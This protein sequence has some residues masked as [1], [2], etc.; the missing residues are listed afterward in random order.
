MSPSSGA[1]EYYLL[2]PKE[3]MTRILQA[4]ARLGEKVLVLGHHY[5]RDDVMR[6]ADVQGDTLSLCLEGRQRPQAE[7]LVL[8]GVRFMAEAADL[9]SGEHQK[10]ILPEPTAGCPLAEMADLKQLEACWEELTELLGEGEVLPLAA[11]PSSAEAK[12]L[13]GR[14]GGAVCAPSNA[15]QVLAWALEQASRVLFFPDQHL[16]RNAGA[17]VGLEEEEMVVWD[18]FRPQGGLSPKT[19]RRARLIL[20]KGHCPV[21][22]RFTLQQVRQMKALNPGLRVIVHGGCRLEVAQAADEW[23]S[24]EDIRRRIASSPPGSQWAVGAELHLV[25]RL[26]KENPDKSILHLDS[27][28]CVCPPMFRIG[29]HSLGWVLE[30]LVQGRIVNQVKVPEEVAPWARKALERMLSLS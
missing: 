29:P 16:G 15:P 3:L 12:A 28:I 6:F 4:K 14:H 30:N 22:Q 23:G 5:L 1:M 21:H 7:Y 9:L 24:S 2:E 26:A 27:C 10:V 18:P 11:L 20:W 8:G 25:H 13:A 17:K 19:L